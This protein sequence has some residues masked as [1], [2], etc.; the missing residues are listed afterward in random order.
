[1]LVDPVFVYDRAVIPVGTRLIGHVD[2]REGVSKKRRSL[3]MLSGDFTPLHDI[4]VRFDDLMLADGR[5]L[6]VRTEVSAGIE[7]VTLAVAEGTEKKQNVVVRAGEEVLE[8]ARRTIALLGPG[9]WERMKDA[10]LRALP[11]HP[12]F[13]SKGTVFAARLRSALDVGAAARPAERAEAGAAAAPGSLLSARMVGPIDSGHASKG[14]PVEAV[15]TRPVFSSTTHQVMV[16]AGARLTGH[17]TFVKRARSFRRNG[18]VRFLFDSVHVTGADAAA[19][20]ASLHAV[21]AGSGQRIAVDEEGGSKVTNSPVRFVAPALGSLALVGLAQGHLD[22]DTDGAGP[23]MAYG[24]PVSG[25][26]AGLVGASVTGLAI[27]SLGHPAAVALGVLGVART[28]YSA[29]FAKGREIA[30]AADT[31]IQVQLAP[32]PR[33]HASKK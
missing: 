3:A 4:G 11:Y 19:L 13:F 5:R 26:V 22:Y 21:E 16:P 20:L 9:R 1:M 31:P 29:V 25:S 24:G 28:T 6:P 32:G 7:R 12:E 30:F 27:S 8:P 17:V 23:E 10:G 15:V 18:Q 33:P 14:T 2:R